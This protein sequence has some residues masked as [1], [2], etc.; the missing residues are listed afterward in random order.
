MSDQD[1]PENENQELLHDLEEAGSSAE[2]VELF[3]ELPTPDVVDFLE[4]KK[5]ADILNYITSLDPDDKGRIF[6]DLHID[7]QIELFGQ[8]P[9]KEMAQI[10]THMYSDVRVDLYQKLDKNEQIELL[11]Y[12]DKKVREDVI[13]LSAYPPETAGG[14]MSTDFA[15]V[16]E[17]MSAQEAL[18][19]IRL[20]APSKEML[21]Y[22]YVVDELMVMKGFISLKNLVLAQ[23]QQVISEILN[24]F[25]VH[26]EVNEDKESV[27]NKI[28]K[29][30]LAAIPVLN[31]LKQL[32]GI[33]GH[34][35]AIEVIRETQTES[36]EKLAG[37]MPS[38][39]DSEYLE[40]SSF[41]HF[42]R[43]V[44]WLVSLAAVGIVSGMIINQ[45]SSILENFIILAMYMPMMAATGGNTGTQTASVVI[46][47]LSLGHISSHDWFKIVSKEFKIS[48]MLSI[49]VASLTYLKIVFLSFSQILPYGFT[50]QKVGIT[51]SLAITIQVISSALLGAGLPI[52]VR[53][54]GGDPAV[55][56]SP[57]ITTIVDITGLL[58]YFS[59]ATAILNMA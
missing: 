45:Y 16:F 6:S 52:A 50:L 38:E 27:A 41:N 14:I 44:I 37:V 9:K 12:L 36:I 29:Y 53:R 58:I 34:D 7:I 51:I 55:V 49:C 17:F 11:P 5:P 32:V 15:T 43:R 4:E 33:V 48:F 2:L 8:I 56:A 59:V 23:P 28:E 22:I 26:A 30:Q 31:S 54:F 1:I 47:A 24:E 25:F 10:F 3:E 20:D 46:R 40:T 19:K 18:S 35:D 13:L 39:S 21:Y 42:K 57:A